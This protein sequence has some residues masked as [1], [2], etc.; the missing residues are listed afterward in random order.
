MRLIV[1]FICLRGFGKRNNR[2]LGGKLLEYYCYLARY[3]A[4][5]VCFAK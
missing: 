5:N 1:V 2:H 4:V 3:H